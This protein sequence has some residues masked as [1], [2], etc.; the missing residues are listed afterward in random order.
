MRFFAPLLRRIA[1][2][3]VDSVG[4]MTVKHSNLP[5]RFIKRSMDVVSMIS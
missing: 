5:R 1:D 4:D 2:R 3:S